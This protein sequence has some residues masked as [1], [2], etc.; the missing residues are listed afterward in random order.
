MY[1]T[2]VDS[3]KYYDAENL[4]VER[5]E[6]QVEENKDGNKKELWTGR[7]IRNVMDKRWEF[8]KKEWIRVPINIRWF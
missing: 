8:W 5:Q 3:Y 6:D 2:Y 1:A 7:I 4:A